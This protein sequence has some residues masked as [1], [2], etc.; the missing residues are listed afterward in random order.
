MADGQIKIAIEVDGKQVEIASKELDNLG[1]SGQ[2]SGKGIKQAED[3]VKGVGNES[4]KASGKVKKFTTAVGLVAISAMAFKTLKSAMDSAISRFDTLNTFPGVLKE[5]GVSAED[6]DRSM[7]SLSDGTDGLP[8]K[9]DE[10]AS[11]AQR[12]YTSFNDMDKATDTA[13]ALNN[14]LLGS[15]SSAEQASR[16]TEQYLK[17]LQ[18]GEMDMQTWR[19]LS[20]TMDVGLVKVAESMGYAGK[21]AKDDLYNALK[22]GERSLDDF[23]DAL[24]DVGTGS[25]VMAEL[26]KENSLGLATS[27]SNLSTAVSRNLANVIE[28]FDELSREVTGKGIAEHI[29]GLKSIINTAFKVIV[30]VIEGATPIVKGF[31]EVLSVAFDVVQMLS[32]ALL[33]LG[34]AF[35]I[36]KVIDTAT[37][38]IKAYTKS[39]TLATGAQLLLTRQMTLAEVA[40]AAKAAMSKTL[41]KALKA[42]MGPVGWVTVGITALG[43]AVYGIIKW[44]NRASEEEKQLTS[45]TKELAEETKTLNNELDN[46]AKE[47]KDN[48]SEINNSAKAN[49]DLVKKISELS[50]KEK[51]SA[52]DKA[53]LKTYTEQLNDSVDGLNIAYDEQTDSLNMT[54]DEMSDYVKLLKDQETLEE[55]QNRMVEVTKE[56]NKAE[57]KLKEIN[58]DREEWNKHLENGGKVGKDAKEAIKELDEE[59]KKLTITSENL[60]FEY[61]ELQDKVVE[62]T[63]SINNNSVAQI[64]ALQDLLEDHEDIFNE[65]KSEYDDLADAAT[66]AFDR[67]ND[68]SKYSVEEMIKNLEHNQEMTAKWGDNVS[69]LMEFASKNGHEGFQKHLETMTIDQAAELQEMADALENWKNDGDTT[70]QELATLYDTNADIAMSAFNK[71]LGG[72]LGD[73]LQQ[74]IKF[75]GESSKSM[76]EKMESAGF[77]DIGKDMSGGVISGIESRF[78][79][80]EVV[81]KRLGEVASSSIKRFA[82]IKSPSR[83]FMRHGEDIAEGTAIGIENG[84]D[85]I[86]SKVKS[87]FDGMM[88]RTKSGFKGVADDSETGVN[89]VG[90]KMLL[91]SIVSNRA[92]DSMLKKVRSGG[93]AQVSY[94]NSLAKSMYRSFDGMPSQLSS[95]GVNAMNGLNIGL[96]SGS[97]RV[98]A[99]A[100][101]IA[102]S[103]ANTMRS[104]LRIHSP[105]RVMRDDVGRW[106][107]EGVAD[108]IESGKSSLSKALNSMTGELMISTPETALGSPQ[109]SRVNSGSVGVSST[110]NQSSNAQSALVGVLKE[111]TN[112]LVQIAKKDPNLYVD[113]ERITGIVNENNALIASLDHF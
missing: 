36:G 86:L 97:G 113:G 22:S 26:A 68:E 112:I 10:I 47:H 29:D 62:T 70:L 20:E 107:P 110:T 63:N 28:S 90:A 72:G 81:S 27:L 11:T 84:E 50:D 92:M 75:P 104:A 38:A 39:S 98:M 4:E 12:M 74:I 64:Q 95:I 55:S 102:N 80:I 87:V 101:S 1:K 35:A 77:F 103:V 23:N 69:E 109:M 79:D 66:D 108:G 57:E 46:S 89:S 49:E 99:T 106:I 71:K 93:S 52:D 43:G 41:G 59:E 96:N 8:T 30:S 56:R 48:I 42:M 17:V 31:Y 61:S 45:Q 100:R 67:I 88:N 14:A 5:L 15:G 51:K 37:K 58:E 32:P 60:R 76:R 33:T 21:T 3:G 40:M 25:G 105:S 19:S 78:D 83:L 9:L 44:F 111:Q 65:I 94:M 54:N 7:Q 91:L 53:L 85:N 13:L 16:G 24:I 18:T 82:E 6:A 34:G 73:A 2:G